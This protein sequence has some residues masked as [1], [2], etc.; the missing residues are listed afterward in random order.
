MTPG[1]DGE[2]PR[3]PSG[4][5]LRSLVENHREFLR[6][7]EK[8]VGRRDL[9]EDIL[10]EAFARGIDRIETLRDGESAVAWFYRTLRNAV[11]DRHRRRNAEERALAA[12]AAEL[13][14]SELPEQEVRGAICQCVSRLAATLKPEY[15]DV[16]E[17]VEVQGLSVKELAAVRGISANNAAV[18][19]HRARAALRSRVMTSC[20]ACAEHGCLDCTCAKPARP[21][22][23][24]AGCGHSH[25]GP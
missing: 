21:A 7:L 15:A 13:G 8:R 5:V 4:E 10:Q 19:L 24:A 9:A 17:R 25:S 18:R 12:F 3:P 20:G 23:P 2:A 14:A 6:F 1:P 11:I 16:L 22:A